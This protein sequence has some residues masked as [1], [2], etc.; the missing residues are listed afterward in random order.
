D[1]ARA[2]GAALAAKSASDALNVEFAAEGLA[3]F[4]L[5]VGLHVGEVV[6]GNPGQAERMEYTALGTTV[7]LAARLEG[8]NKDY[9]TS[10]LVSEAVRDRVG[11]EFGFKPVAS[12]IAKGMS[13][14]TQVYELLASADEKKSPDVRLQAIRH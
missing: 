11:N 14:P 13:K 1:V 2:C 10:I 3:P 7:N 6:V 8:L 5:R 12:V 4:Q 9:G